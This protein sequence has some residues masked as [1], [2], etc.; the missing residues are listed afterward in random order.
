V[1]DQPVQPVKV[2]KPVAAAAP[3]VVAPVVA[4]PA[5][6]QPVA[7]AVAKSPPPPTGGGASFIS[8]YPINGEIG[9]PLADAVPGGTRGRT[10]T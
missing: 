10:C 9:L 8:P 4:A 1:A 5:P 7:A 2:V 3:K 6:V